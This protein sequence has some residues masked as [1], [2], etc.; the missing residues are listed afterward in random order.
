MDLSTGDN[1]D[2]VFLTDAGGQL[3]VEANEPTG[4]AESSEEERVRY[5]RVIRELND[6]EVAYEGSTVS[7]RYLSTRTGGP[8]ES[9]T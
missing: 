2:D 6:F 7:A 5:E 4:L 9:V 3:M 1:F 8:T